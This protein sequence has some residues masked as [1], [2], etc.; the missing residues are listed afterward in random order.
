M[1]PYFPLLIVLLLVSTSFIG[2]SFTV[3]ESFPIIKSN[4]PP[5]EPS[6]PFPFDGECGVPIDLSLCWVGGD[7][8]PDDMVTY[9]VYFGE[10]TNPPYYAIIGPFSANITDFEFK[11]ISLLEICS[12]YYWKI[13]SKDN[14]GLVSEGP[15]WSF[16]TKCWLFDPPTIYG[17]KSG[18]VGVEYDYI[19]VQTNHDG[20]DISY[21]ID[22]G[23][24]TTTG[25]T[26]YY[27]QDTHV[28]RNH[29]WNEKGDYRIKAKV[30]TKF[31]LES[32]WGY[33]DVTMPKSHNPIWWLNSLLD[34]FPLL[35]RLLGWL[36]R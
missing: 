29:T 18:K 21:F 28:I 13:I 5:Y 17:P 24:N 8:D 6:N 12:T 26:D 3:E 9:E 32:E 25:W 10:E 2:V 34:R 1:K 20:D 15:I 19:F 22:W 30:K 27:E 36:I 23:D 33:L 16:T 14:H 31:G 11:I 4:N 35:S 7:P